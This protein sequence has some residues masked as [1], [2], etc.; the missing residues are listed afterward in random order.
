MTVEPVKSA[1]MDFVD[2]RRPA[3]TAPKIAMHVP[4]F[5]VT[6]HVTCLR[7]ARNAPK[8]VAIARVFAMPWAPRFVVELATRSLGQAHVQTT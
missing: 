3:R 6:G 2:S 1:E 7:R 5:A 8:I 4:L